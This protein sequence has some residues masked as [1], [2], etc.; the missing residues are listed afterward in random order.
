MKKAETRKERVRINLSV[1]DVVDASEVLIM[2]GMWSWRQ[3]LERLRKPVS[4]ERYL[5]KGGKGSDDVL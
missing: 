3:A 5:N 1:R 2:V 4:A